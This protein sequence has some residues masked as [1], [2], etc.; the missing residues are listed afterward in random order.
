MR[1]LLD[2][3]RAALPRAAEMV[4][5]PYGNLPHQRPA[6]A[7]ACEGLVLQVAK[8]DCDLLRIPTIA[9]PSS[10]SA[11]VSGSGTGVSR[12]PWETPSR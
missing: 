3:M 8:G 7:E 2:V 1:L 10:S 9:S 11:Q 4:A 6:Q 5:G 12:K